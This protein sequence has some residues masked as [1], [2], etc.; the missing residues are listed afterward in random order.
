MTRE[1]RLTR[2][3]LSALASE[4]ALDIDAKVESGQP[5][6]PDLVKIPAE[7]R[8]PLAL[9]ALIKVAGG[10][11]AL[12]AAEQAN[13]RADEL[14]AQAAARVQHRVAEAIFVGLVTQRLNVLEPGLDGFPRLVVDDQMGKEIGFLAAVARCAGDVWVYSDGEV[15]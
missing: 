11:E 12:Q 6:D 2:K 10:E 7:E 5:I 1:V 8:R 15:E 3:M 14:L 4:I 9:A 13:A